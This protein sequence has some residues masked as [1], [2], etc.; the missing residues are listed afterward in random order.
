MIEIGNYD[1]FYDTG[2]EFSS[3]KILKLTKETREMLPDITLSVTVPH[4]LSLLDQVRLA[5][6]LEEEGA[7]IIQTEGGKCSSPTKPGVLGLIEKVWQ[8]LQKKKDLTIKFSIQC[9]LINTV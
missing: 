1:S 2:I 7:D 6:L 4:T 9:K 5:E 3:E 8:K